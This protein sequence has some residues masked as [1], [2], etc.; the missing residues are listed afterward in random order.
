MSAQDRMLI[1]IGA[2]AAIC[3]VFAWLVNGQPWV[4]AVMFLQCLAYLAMAVH[5]IWIRRKKAR[6]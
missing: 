2:V 5:S 4:A 1:A 3:S 6:T